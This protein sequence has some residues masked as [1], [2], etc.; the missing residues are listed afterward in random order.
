MLLHLSPRDWLFIFLGVLLCCY[1]KMAQAKTQPAL[2]PLF[3][4]AKFT[5]LI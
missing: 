5:R 4:M 1:L 3:K 2:N